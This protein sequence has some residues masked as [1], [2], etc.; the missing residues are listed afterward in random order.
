MFVDSHFLLT[1]QMRDGVIRRGVF[2]RLPGQIHADCSIEPAH[3][4]DPPLV[5]NA[6]DFPLLRPLSRAGYRVLLEAGVRVLEWNGAMLHTKT[7]VADGRWARVGSTNLNIASWFGNCEMDIVIEDEA[8]AHQMEQMFHD[9]LANSTEVFLD[10][11]QRVRVPNQPGHHRRRTTSGRGT[12]GHA[13]AGAVRIVNA[14]AAAFTYRRV[15]EPVESRIMVTA[16]VALF[17]LAILFAWFPRLLAY[18]LVL[19]FAWIA[20]ALL[21]HSYKLRRSRAKHSAPEEMTKAEWI[22]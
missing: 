9:D 18:P 20:S 14:V 11:K 12:S 13:A 3:R 21:Y 8:F 5:P 1:V 2:H 17:A 15:I 6:T 7:A 19:L 22:D 10:A 16:G 4:S